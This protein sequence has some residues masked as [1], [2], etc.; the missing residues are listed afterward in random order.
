MNYYTVTQVAGEL[1]RQNGVSPEQAVSQL[2]AFLESVDSWMVSGVNVLERFTQTFG[3]SE[4][5][6]LD[7][8]FS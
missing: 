7:L 4:D 1:V 2:L 8:L 6:L 5:Y 3:L